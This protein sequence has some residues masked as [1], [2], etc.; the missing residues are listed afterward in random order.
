MR[1]KEVCNTLLVIVF[2]LICFLVESADAT[3][4]KKHLS[5]G[6][7]DLTFGLKASTWWMHQENAYFGDFDQTWAETFG[8]AKVF[9]DDKDK[10]QGEIR[11]LGE[12]TSG[13]DPYGTG[14]GSAVTSTVPATTM[15]IERAYIKL[16]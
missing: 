16:N 1:T 4:T 10:Y 2:F 5:I 3:R 8:Y 6:D 14:T 9:L 13:Q 15:A 7:V 11:I 12:R